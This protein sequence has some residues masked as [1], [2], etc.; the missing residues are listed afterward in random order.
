[1]VQTSRNRVEVVVQRVSTANDIPPD[2]EIERCASA[3]L[4]GAVECASINLRIVD[5]AEGAELNMRWRN[6][7]GATNVLSFPAEGV[8]LAAPGF[9]GDIVV[10]APLVAREAAEQNKPSQAHWAHLV[11]HGLLHLQGYDHQT[12]ADAEIMENLERDV[13]A[14]I[15]FP[16]PYSVIDSP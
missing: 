7:S 5:E 3:A 12:D 16:D 6:R 13:M 15:G 11:V 8:E 10:C 9:L 2:S 14:S 1:M 4:Q